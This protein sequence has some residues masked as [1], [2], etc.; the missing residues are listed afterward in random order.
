MAYDVDSDELWYSNG[1]QWLPLYAYTHHVYAYAEG[2]SEMI[3][4]TDTDVTFDRCDLTSGFSTTP[5]GTTFVVGVSGDYRFAYTVVGYPGAN[6]APLEFSIYIDGVS[7][8]PEYE[9]RGGRVVVAGDSTMITGRGIISLEEGEAVTFR[10]RTFVGASSVTL[11]ASR[12]FS[13]ELIG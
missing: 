8:G 4:A 7:A 5:P 11:T 10:N 13:L 2:T 6:T 1:L 3:V 12:S 9:F